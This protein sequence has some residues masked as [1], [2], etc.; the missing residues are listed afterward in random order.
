MSN[1]SIDELK[2]II[3]KQDF[4]LDR[5]MSVCIDAGTAANSF[6]EYA[7]RALLKDIF[8]TWREVCNES[9]PMF[10]IIKEFEY[11]Y[12]AQRNK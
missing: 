10:K 11:E 12:I 6:S 8:N 1:I 4:L 7:C 2:K 3:L 9:E 5:I